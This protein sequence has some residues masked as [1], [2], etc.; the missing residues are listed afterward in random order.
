MLQLERDRRGLR[1]RRN[2]NTLQLLW[3]DDT[4]LAELGAGL[5]DDLH[6]FRPK[7]GREIVVYTENPSLPYGGVQVFD[8]DTGDCLYD[9]FYQESAFEE[10]VGTTKVP[11]NR[12]KA[13]L[14][15]WEG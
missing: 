7:G 4:R 13:L 6:Y 10:A 15:G 3:A 5:D 1:L 14:A 9:V 2:D 8:Y 12:A 11:V